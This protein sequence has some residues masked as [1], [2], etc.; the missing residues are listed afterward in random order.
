M[1][2]YDFETFK[3]DTLL[4]VLNEETGEVI[5]TWSISEIKELAED[6]L[7]N[8]WIGYNCEHY[9]KI[10]LH[11]I[12]SGKLN[13]PDKVFAC[14]N[15]VIHAQDAD[16]PVFN[17]LGKHGITDYYSSPILSYDVMGDGSFMSL[18]QNEG[19]MGMDIVES[20][21]P[22]DLDRPLTEEEKRDVEKYNRADLY[23]TLERFKQRKNSFKTKM[24]LV[25]EFGLPINYICKTNAK[26]TEAILLSQNK[27][28]NTRLRKNFQLCDLPVNW[29]VP[30]LKTI[31]DFFIEAL[32]ELEKHNW[33]TKKCDKTKLSMDLDILG[34]IH[35][36][37]LGGVHGGI[38]NYICRPEDKKRIIWVDVSSLYPNILT[39][40]DLLSRKVDKNGCIAFAGMVQTRMDV[41]A[42]LHDSSLSKEEKKEL[43]DKAA[44]YKL[45]LNT[46][47]GC[48][49]DKFKKLYD[50]EYNTKMCMLGQLS[51]MDLVFRLKNAK[52]KPKPAWAVEEGMLISTTPEYFKLIQS[53][54]DGIA[55]ELLT[56]DAEDIIDEV[57]KGW[58]KDWRFSLEKTVADNLYEKDVNNYVFRDSDGKVKVK[59][60][61]VTKYDEGNEQDTLAILAQAVVNYFLEG[62]DIRTTICNPENLAT[63]YQMIKKLGGM[64]DT[65]TWKRE[66]GDVEVQKVN[67]IFPSTDLKNGGLYKHKKSK[68][69]GVLDK[70]E[71][72]PEHVLIYNNDIRGK[73]IGELD[74]IDYEWYVAEAQKRINDFLGIKP[75]RKTRR[76]KVIE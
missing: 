16:I 65:P 31:Y 55:L 68:D 10:L 22:F 50:P 57:C 67:R 42:K 70:V 8:I 48:M 33:E 21:V 44:R 17:V 49:K 7:S 54:T 66:Y 24:L 41:K 38:K 12:L 40:W 46:T 9:D 74:D 76:K 4:G 27:G 23:G 69:I 53:N 63:D 59:G 15:S 6:G 61:Y 56:H 14:S 25:R 32:R 1:L 39:K 11:G 35:T 34:V 5:Q 52:R 64:Y 29:D 51:L 28:V 2:I 43:K 45:I 19:F 18:K 30:E 47:S 20:V 62:T 72:T 37:A 58:E 71:G 3:H 73:K 60:A 75:E 26:L 36:F 13:S